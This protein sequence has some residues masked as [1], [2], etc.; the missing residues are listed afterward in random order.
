MLDLHKLVWESD[1][2]KDKKKPLPILGSLHNVITQ[3]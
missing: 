2:V 1:Q 3:L